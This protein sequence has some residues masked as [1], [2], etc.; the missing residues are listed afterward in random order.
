M[1]LKQITSKPDQKLYTNTFRL[2][3]STL[4]W[5]A[6]FYPQPIL[7]YRRRSTQGLA[8]DFPTTNTLGF[9]CYMIYTVAFLYSPLIRQQYAAR[10]PISP[11]PSVRFNDLAFAVHAVILSSLVFSQFWPSIW[12]FKVSR[13]Q[14]ISKPIA[15]IFW[16]CILA[17]AVLIVVVAA[18]GT[19]P[20]L[21][22]KD[23]A[24]IDVTYALSYV[25]L[26]ITIIKYIPQAWVNYKRKST[27]G[28]SISA[29][30]LDFSGG[31]LSVLQLLIDSALEEDWSGVT[32]NPIKL[33]LGNVSIFFDIIFMLQHYVLYREKWVGG[34][35]G[36]A[37]AGVVV[38]SEDR[39]GDEDDEGVFAPLLGGRGGDGGRSRPRVALA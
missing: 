17:V 32:G 38:E 30:L 9:I 16:G 20:S 7:N 23:W 36:G 21:D 2:L 12:G 35:V 26:I 29:I 27:V 14:R 10:H 19:G 39:D 11:V 25:K 18:R 24:W 34:N 15:G 5:S 1:K 4:C 8:I 6:S 3:P 37:G 28:W 33:L 13:F 31:V 22:P